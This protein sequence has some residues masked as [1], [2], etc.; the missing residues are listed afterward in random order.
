MTVKVY[1]EEDSG[2]GGVGDITSVIAGLGLTGGA[3]SGDATVNVGVGDGIIVNANDVAVDQ[4]FDFTFAPS[5]GTLNVTGILAATTVTGANVTSGVDP[6]HTHTSSSISIDRLVSATTSSGQ[7]LVFTSDGI[8]DVLSYPNAALLITSS[9]SSGL[10]ISSARIA[11]V[12]ADLLIQGVGGSGIDWIVDVDASGNLTF[13][14]SGVERA[15]ITSSGLTVVGTMGAD[16]VTGANVTS[17]ED[18]GHT[19]TSASIAT[20]RLTSVTGVAGGELVLTHD[21]SF[22]TLTGSPSDVVFVD[23]GAWAWRGGGSSG[24]YIYNNNAADQAKL[25]FIDPDAPSTD[26]YFW[27]FDTTTGHMTLLGGAGISSPG[28]RCN[29]MD[30]IVDGKTGST[31]K[32]DFGVSGVGSELNL[33]FIT[34]TTQTLRWNNIG[35]QFELTESIDIDG[36]VQ[37][38]GPKLTTLT[39]AATIA[40]DAGEIGHQGLAHVTLGGNRTMGNPTN[41]VDGQMIRFRV[42]QDGTGTRTLAWDTDWRFGDNIT[43]TNLNGA[44]NTLSYITAQ[45]DSTDTRWDIVNFQTGY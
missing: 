13:D 23:G 42:L 22:L 31:K 7:E 27:T 35:S 44:A 29:N 10:S 9:G 32:I 5:S 30:L 40:V 3:T 1:P 36:H 24:I 17:G 8:V 34:G 37:S 38:N 19:H 21:G 20:D 45:Y 6:G 26:L 11:A 25:F 39:D 15:S 43:Q 4:T 28:L 12:L 18:P 41:S 33:N 16:T 2:G 14:R